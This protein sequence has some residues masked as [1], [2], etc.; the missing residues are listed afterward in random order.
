[1]SFVRLNFQL[2]GRGFLLVSSSYMC[3]RSSTSAT[4]A[5]SF[6]VNMD[7]APVAD[8]VP[9][10][11][12]ASNQPIG[13][14]H[15]EYGHDPVTAGTHAAAFIAGMTAESNRNRIR[16]AATA[17]FLRGQLHSRSDAFTAPGK[18]VPAVIRKA[19]QRN[20]HMLS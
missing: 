13:V 3:K 8:V 15:R 6:G 10:G 2:N 19:M 9:P 5:K 12:D 18:S 11:T 4:L 20:R 14:L 17:N 7:F 1:M 16:N